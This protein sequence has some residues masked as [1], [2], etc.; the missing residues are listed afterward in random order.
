MVCKEYFLG[1][2]QYTDTTSSS[3][4]KNPCEASS[5]IFFHRYKIRVSKSDPP[6]PSRPNRKLFDP[7]PALADDESPLL[8]TKTSRLVSESS[9]E[10]L[11]PTDLTSEI[12][13]FIALPFSHKRK[14]SEFYQDP[15][16]SL[17]DPARS[18]RNPLRSGQISTKSIEIQPNLYHRL[19]SL[20]SIDLD[21]NWSKPTRLMVFDGLW[22]STSLL[23]EVVRSVLSWTQTL[24][25][26]NP[27]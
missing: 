27:T 18:W 20:L 10:K 2:L 21:R 16:R 17:W 13:L 6:K 5:S 15:V 9:H 7:T 22:R 24:P 8:G 19:R 1:W 14:S 3:F 12:S 25:M 26:D 4:I 11:S 23:V